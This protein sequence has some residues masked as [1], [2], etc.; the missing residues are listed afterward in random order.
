MYGIIKMIRKVTVF[1]INGSAF[2][3]SIVIFFL[4]SAKTPC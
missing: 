2:S 1:S 3:V 4:F